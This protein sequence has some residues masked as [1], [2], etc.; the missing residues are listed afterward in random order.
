MDL[1]NLTITLL[2][3]LLFYGFRRWT[4]R[5]R[6]KGEYTSFVWYLSLLLLGALL[7][8]PIRQTFGEPRPGA[9]LE[10]HRYAAILDAVAGPSGEPMRPALIQIRAGQ[11]SS[12]DY[13]RQGIR[14]AETSVMRGSRAYRVDWIER[15]GER[16]LL[17]SDSAFLRWKRPATL[18][19]REGREWRVELLR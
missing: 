7:I 13:R 2:P 11:T 1:A 14:A 9:F 17:D 12:L 5:P 15:D 16:I 3:P 6:F 19:D 18:L 4:G 8:Y 10:K